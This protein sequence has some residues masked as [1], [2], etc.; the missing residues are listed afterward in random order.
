[1][2]KAQ[3]I[4]DLAVLILAA[5][6]GTRMKSDM[7]KVLHFLGGK[8]LLS[9]SLDLAQ[10]LGSERT[11]VVVGHQAGRVKE[12]FAGN[13]GL[14]YVLQ[15]P[16]LGTGHAV[17]A[18]AP[19]LKDWQ[20][21]VLILCGDVP[22]LK[23]ETCRRLLDRHLRN[24]EALTVLGMDLPDPAAYGRMVLDDQDRLTR[25]VEFRDASDEER[26]INLVN[27]GIYV[28]QA[29]AMLEF[30]PRLA[31]DNDQQEYYLTDLVEMMHGDGLKVGYA[32]CPDPLEVAG[33]NSKEELTDLE[34][35]LTVGK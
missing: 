13:P 22:G 6:K 25:I 15:E 11:M 10:E 28:G 18:A 12:A 19:E 34:Q 32:V 14:L 21:P 17:M 3:T 2:E 31:T 1:M 20:G 30:L 33:V 26:A 5:G 8:P 27:A 16:Q 9:Y 24:G 4:K 35:K 23:A 29:R 7:P